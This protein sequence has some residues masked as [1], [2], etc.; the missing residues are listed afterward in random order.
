[1]HTLNCHAFLILY[2]V[3]EEL[4]VALLIFSFRYGSFRDLDIR[5]GREGEGGKGGKGR[6]GREAIVPISL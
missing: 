2:A 5:K 1:M 4:E 6:E 3:N